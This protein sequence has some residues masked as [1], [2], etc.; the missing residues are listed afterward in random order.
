MIGFTSVLTCFEGSFIEILLNFIKSPLKPVRYRIMST[1]SS[2]LSEHTMELIESV[3]CELLYL[4]K[5]QG[6][7]VA[8][9]IR[10]TLK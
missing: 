4:T 1:L 7:I 6:E 3:Y 10:V 5:E 2:L 8:L 9:L